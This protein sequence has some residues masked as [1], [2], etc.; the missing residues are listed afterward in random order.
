MET[1]APGDPGAIARAD[2][3]L[4]RAPGSLGN[5]TLALERWLRD[6]GSRERTS[7]GGPGSGGAVSAATTWV[8]ARERRG[9]QG[10]CP[11]RPAARRTAPAR[12]PNT[13]AFS[14]GCG[15]RLRRLSSRRLVAAPQPGPPRSA[16]SPWVSASYLAFGLGHP[17]A[18]GARSAVWSRG[19]CSRPSGWSVDIL[20][21]RNPGV[22]ALSVPASGKGGTSQ[23]WILQSW[24]PPEANSD[25]PH[26]IPNLSSQRGQGPSGTN[27][28]QSRE[29]LAL[30]RSPPDTSWRTPPSRVAPGSFL[31]KTAAHPCRSSP[32][33][34]P[35]AVSPFLLFKRLLPELNFVLFI[36]TQISFLLFLLFL[37]ADPHSLPRGWGLASVPKA[38]RIPT[39]KC[40]V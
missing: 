5:L 1:R 29:V 14:P 28:T 17:E 25:R 4:P 33:T 36:P 38:C 37:P 26:P 27:N 39:V 23:M 20:N 40:Q 31:Q 34:R 22:S 19:T 18:R 30:K 32:Y 35:T 16:P 12:P 9:L 3:R 6:L 11:A 15:N 21:P 8:T 10:L 7:G 24:N 13:S 2:R